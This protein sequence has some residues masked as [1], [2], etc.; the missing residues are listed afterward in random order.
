MCARQS[1]ADLS[2][3]VIFLACDALGI[4]GSAVRGFRGPGRLEKLAVVVGG[5]GLGVIAGGGAGLSPLSSP[6]SVSEQ[7]VD[8]GAGAA[9]NGGG[10]GD[11]RG[12]FF[13]SS[14]SSATSTTSLENQKRVHTVQKT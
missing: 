6:F 8:T 12:H 14:E 11:Q 4:E 1:I 10:R 5:T 9:S 3:V 2:S 7:G 13:A